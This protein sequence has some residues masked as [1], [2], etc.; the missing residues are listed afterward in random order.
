MGSMFSFNTDEEIPLRNT[1]NTDDLAYTDSLES[2]SKEPFE[3][4]NTG[5]CSL[6]GSLSNIHAVIELSDGRL[7]SASDDHNIRLW[8]ISKQICE[9]SWNAH[10]FRVYSL[11]LLADGRLASAGGEHHSR[12]SSIKVW[13][14]TTYT[15]VATAVLTDHS[16][17]P[18]L[19]QLADGR[20]ACSGRGPDIQ[21][22]EL[23][24][25][26]FTCALLLIDDQIKADLLVQ[27]SDRRLVSAG[28][29]DNAI[30]IWDLS[31][32]SC[33]LRIK[34]KV[35][36][37]CA[38]YQLND[39]RLAV[40]TGSY[41][42]EVG[43]IRI[44]NLST[45]L[46]EVTLPG[47]HDGTHSFCQLLDGRLVSGGRDTSPKFRPLGTEIIKIWDLTT[48]RCVGTIYGS[49][50]W[51]DDVIQLTDGRLASAGTFPNLVN[52]WD[53]YPVSLFF[54]ACNIDTDFFYFARYAVKYFRIGQL[55][56][57]I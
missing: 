36:G 28:M 54:F 18:C 2:T 21:I 25:D 3:I 26:N 41:S 30:R 49:S 11:V 50:S 17:C 56:E 20:L 57:L 4:V 53:I 44:L 37:I 39:G 38:I 5:N 19:I 55:E 46:C 7:A 27:L 45:G 8:N 40:G 48:K 42:V 9:N 35:S 52:V 29:F 10:P 43:N 23:I 34:E 15:C 22:W 31:T 32:G 16:C 1:N 6:E 47:H 51:V 33:L 13:D 12:G 24:G 14:L